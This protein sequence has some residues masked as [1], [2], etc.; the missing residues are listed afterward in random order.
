MKI[1][2]IKCVY[3]RE[4]IAGLFTAHRIPTGK[5]VIQYK[6][7]GMFEHRKIQEQ[8]SPPLEQNEVDSYCDKLKQRIISQFNQNRIMH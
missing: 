6:P 8:I 4:N 3:Y 2:G 1:N 7:N 5:Y